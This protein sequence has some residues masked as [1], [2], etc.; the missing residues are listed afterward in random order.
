VIDATAVEQ[1]T[2]RDGRTVVEAGTAMKL[3]VTNSE[4]Y[5]PYDGS[6]VIR[7]ILLRPVELMA[8]ATA[9]NEP[10]PLVFTNAVFYTTQIVNFTTYAA[11]LQN[12]TSSVMT[13][14]RFE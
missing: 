7:G 6:G 11:A 1:T 4:R 8:R 2:D 5:V 13:N 14:C 3:S 9:A 12:S 10:A